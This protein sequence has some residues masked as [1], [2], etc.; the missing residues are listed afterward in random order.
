MYV[1]PTK[2]SIS[3][4][5]LPVRSCKHPGMETWFLCVAW[6]S[7]RS[8]RPTPCLLLHSSIRNRRLPFQMLETR[9]LSALPPSA[10]TWVASLYLTW[11][12]TRAGCAY[13][14]DLFMTSL[15]VWDKDLLL[16]TFHGLTIRCMVPSSVLRRCSILMSLPSSSTS[17]LVFSTNSILLCVH[18]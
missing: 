7:L 13:V 14:T 4:N 10:L 18:L 9:Q 16:L 1:I 17:D 6:R 15:A 12:H 2:S 11:V 5:C 3:L 8:T